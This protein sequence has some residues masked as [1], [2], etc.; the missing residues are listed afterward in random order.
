MDVNQKDPYLHV[1]FSLGAGQSAL[2][3]T[4]E[5]FLVCASKPPLQGPQE[6]PQAPQGESGE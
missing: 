3:Q 6:P 5:C 1:L 4:H 2:R